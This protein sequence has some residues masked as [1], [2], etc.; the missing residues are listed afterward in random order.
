[1]E[2]SKVNQPIDILTLPQKE[3]T[4]LCQEIRDILEQRVLEEKD[5]AKK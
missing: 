5:L 1:M 2:K 3:R 4:R